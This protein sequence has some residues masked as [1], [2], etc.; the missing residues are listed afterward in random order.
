MR[1]IILYD[2][3]YYTITNGFREVSMDILLQGEIVDDT[4]GNNCYCSVSN[5]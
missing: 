1:Y 4:T 5:T 2:V 3:I